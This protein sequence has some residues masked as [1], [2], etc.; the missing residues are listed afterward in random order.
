MPLPAGTRYRVKTT[1]GGKKIRLAF[2][3]GTNRV[4]E[5][6]NLQTG[7]LHSMADFARERR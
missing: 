6:K 1:T 7:K 3:K 2:R 4:I 5:T